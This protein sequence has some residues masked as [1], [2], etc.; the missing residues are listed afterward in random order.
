MFLRNLTIALLF[1]AIFISAKPLLA[2]EPVPGAEIFV[3]LEPDDQPIM[4][5]KTDHIGTYHFKNLKKGKYKI[6][7]K[8]P[9]T[10]GDWAKKAETVKQKKLFVNFIVNGIQKSPITFGS[11][12]GKNPL[13][14]ESPKFILDNTANSIIVKLE[15]SLN[16][17]GIN[18]EGIK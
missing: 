4:K 9:G 17:Y 15:T 11:K 2:G 1:L 14:F 5:G 6:V 16:N 18:D 7:C 13:L 12:T 10:Q 8:L 3:E